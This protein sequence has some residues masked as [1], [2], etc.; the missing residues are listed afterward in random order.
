MGN[1]PPLSQLART[2]PVRL[3]ASWRDSDFP[4]RG[5]VNPYGIPVPN[6]HEQE[7]PDELDGIDLDAAEARLDA[8]E[9]EHK[10]LDQ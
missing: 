4:G 5:D 8:W 10:E 1:L 7:G 3:M 9:S 2:L 6:P